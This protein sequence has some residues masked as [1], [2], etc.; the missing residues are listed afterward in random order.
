[1]WVEEKI[2]IRNAE[3]LHARPARMLWEVARRFRCEIHIVKGAVDADAKSIFDIM[4]LDAGEGT[5]LAVR[6]R[7][8]NAERAVRAIAQLIRGGFKEPGGP[9]R[10]A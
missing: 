2:A 3:G 4:T 5:V 8:E 7:G 10:K 1:M 6:A 9:A